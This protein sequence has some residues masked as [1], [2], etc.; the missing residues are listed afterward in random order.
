MSSKLIKEKYLGYISSIVLCFCFFQV[1]SNYPYVIKVNKLDSYHFFDPPP[2]PPRESGQT[3]RSQAN[4]ISVAKGVSKL[5]KK[6]Y[7]DYIF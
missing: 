2:P 1:F 5:I 7:L 6:K 3:D 4:F